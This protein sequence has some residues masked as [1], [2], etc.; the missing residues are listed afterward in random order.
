V[1]LPAARSRSAMGG[2]QGSK[3]LIPI[4]TAMLVLA[5]GAL[6]VC[7]TEEADLTGAS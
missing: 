6:C 4:C 5:K 3:D 7:G 1:H 2:P